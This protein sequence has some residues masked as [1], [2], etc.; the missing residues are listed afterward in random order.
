MF[1]HLVVVALSIPLALSAATDVG[2]NVPDSCQIIPG[3]FS[4]DTHVNVLDVVTLVTGI[5]AGTALGGESRCA[6]CYGDLAVA[7]YPGD[8]LAPECTAEPGNMDTSTGVN[9]LHVVNFVSYILGTNTTGFLAQESACTPCIEAY[10]SS[11]TYAPGLLAGGLASFEMLSMAAN[12]GNLDLVAAAS[13]ATDGV[14]P[15]G[16][17]AAWMIWGHGE[18]DVMAF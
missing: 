5:L 1:R 17:N 16:P 18:D 14:D 4:G 10:S 3:D 15:I 11:A 13:G 12:P 8:V 9:V 6:A 2:A 7:P